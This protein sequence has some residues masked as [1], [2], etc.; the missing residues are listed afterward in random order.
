[1]PRKKVTTEPVISSDQPVDATPAKKARAKSSAAE[2]TVEPVKKPRRTTKKATEPE[3]AEAPSIAI[4]AFS[5]DS[6]EEGLVVMLRPIQRKSTKPAVTP[7]SPAAKAAPVEEASSANDDD[8]LLLPVFR[9]RAAA[10]KKPARNRQPEPTEEPTRQ[11]NLAEP[12]IA[13]SAELEFER[14]DDGLA[15]AFRT[16]SASK[17]TSRREPKPVATPVVEEPFQPAA[18]VKVI[19]P[20]VALESTSI[21]DEDTPDGALTINWRTI[22]NDTVKPTREARDTE[23]DDDRRGRRGQRGFRERSETTAESSEVVVA[24]EPVA[25]AAAPRA[26]EIAIPSD[27]PQVVLRNGL[28]TL[29]RDHRVYPPLMLY[30][31]ARDSKRTDIL[32]EEVKLAS[33]SGIHLHMVAI[34][35]EVSETGLEEA[36][37]LAENLLVA[38]VK[39]D[40]EAQVIF[41]VEF[42]ADRGWDT[43]YPDA[44]FRGLDGSLAQPSI[45]DDAFWQD[46]ELHLAQFVRN[47]LI[48]PLKG[49]AMG[50]HLERN[51]WFLSDLDG[52]DDSHAAQR[53]FRDWARTRYNQD[54][55]ALRASWFDGSANFA[56]IDVPQFLPEGADGERFVRSSRRQRRYVDYHLFL[57]DETVRR[58]R[59]LAYAAKE[60]SNGY[61]LVGVS[62]GYTFEWSHPSNGHLALG[63]LLRAEEVDYIAGPPS[64]RNREP[65]GTGSFPAPIDSFALNGKLYVSL[66]D[67]RTSLGELAD[68]DSDHNP[69]LKT[70]Q[71]LESVHWRG[72]GAA[73]SHGAGAAWM[74]LWGNGWLRTASVWSLA[75]KLR[76]ALIL[77]MEATSP[78]PEVAVFVDERSLAYLVDQNAFALLVQNVR[79]SVLRAGVSVGFYLLSDLAHREVFPESKLY[80]FLNAWDI[81][82]DLRAAIKTRLQKD[83]KVLFWL[84]TAGMFDSGRDALERA[85]EVTGIAL[86]PQPFYSKAGTNLV[87]RR[88]PLAEAFPEK[89]IS[90]NAQLEPSYF[91]IPEDATVLG[92]YSQ[93]GLASFVVRKFD[94]DAEGNWTSVF[95]GEPVV[96][97]QLIRALA[98]MAGAHVWNFQNDVVHVRSPFLT[99]HC[100]GAGSRNIALPEKFSAYDLVNDQWAS[101]DSAQLRF[102]AV[103]GSTHVFLVGQKTE[104][105]HM[106]KT[107]PTDV[108]HIEDIPARVAN[109]RNDIEAFDVPVMKLGEWM[110]GADP[111][112]SVD[113]WFLRPQ[114]EEEGLTPAVGNVDEP[115]HRRRRRRTGRTNDRNNAPTNRQSEFHAPAVPN[116]DQVVNVMFRKRD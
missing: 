49:H 70:P 66:E 78:D 93:S 75:A 43:K 33:D 84:Y 110:T 10:E 55:V 21:A 115:G 86:K 69:L 83:G 38:I 116:A 41:R 57:S 101:I 28:P 64:Y 104:I 29:V 18:P 79:E 9:S 77:R 5:A 56:D 2:P 12:A 108:L 111:E 36:T 95:L 72:A 39:V 16:R 105:E 71:A 34:D 82:P 14:T 59:S 113:E 53:K 63:K 91:A 19:T 24:E 102:T 48:G 74:D 51:E 99:V 92:E 17:P 89:T 1:M 67:Y 45:C 26:R 42:T 15:V 23:R 61:F 37:T 65:G 81:R 114:V 30:G 87:N 11:I 50:V 8:D 97:P 103:D 76:E 35:L 96:N 58:I 54:V 4:E 73:L 52:Y 85:R 3:V 46:A 90:G 80:L 94:D 31:R 27:A 6:A 13:V 60:A 25:P 68:P 32:L 109:V 20:S 7:P 112:E 100:T 40:P 107:N 22:G 98:Q 62:Y 47:L 88:H 44:K 106:L